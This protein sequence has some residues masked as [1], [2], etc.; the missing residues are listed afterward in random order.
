MKS[1]EQM[2]Q[3]VRR[4]NLEPDAEAR[5]R[6]LR[7]LVKVHTQ[8]KEKP[9]AAG[10]WNLTRIIMTHGTKKL[11]A[12][13]ALALILA[14][15][16]S[17]GAGSVAFSQAGHAV[18]ATLAWLRQAVVGPTPGEPSVQPPVVPAGTAGANPKAI[19]YAARLFRVP[20]DETGVWQSLE[21]GIEFI[22]VSVDPEV[23]YATL[24]REQ[25]EAFEASLTLP[26]LSAPCVTVSA[27]NVAT[28]ALT[29]SAPLGSRH[30]FALGL[31]PMLSSGREEV[32][33]TLS[34]HDGHNGFEIPNLCT[35]SGG[36]V[37]I[38]AKGMSPDLDEA[39]EPGGRRSTEFL[40][41]IQ[42]NVQ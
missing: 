20:E 33:S 4:L 30:G 16:F 13:F 3:S 41:R 35:E 37:L 19:C 24:T 29:D 27:G 22:K 1:A 17:L 26:C 2:E 32:Q 7:D 34:F 6:T 8:Q 31:L 25:G 21:K 14:G 42:V 10:R 40:I 5:E 15:A 9:S 23:Y 11:A 39:T 28:L 12:V 36:V 18:N 38:R